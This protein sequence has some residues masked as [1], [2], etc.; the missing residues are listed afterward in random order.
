L[1][2]SDDVRD[3]STIDDER[4]SVENCVEQR[5]WDSDFAED[6]ESADY[7]CNTVDIIDIPFFKLKDE[8][9]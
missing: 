5:E 8:V 4:R 6:T 2:L 3:G 1:I 7:C 9:G